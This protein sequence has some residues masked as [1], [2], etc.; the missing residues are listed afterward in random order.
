MEGHQEAALGSTVSFWML[1]IGFEKWQLRITESSP[2]LFP[3]HVSKLLFIFVGLTVLR[4]QSCTSL[5]YKVEA[6]CLNAEPRTERN[7][8]HPHSPAICKTIGEGDSEVSSKKG[9]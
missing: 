1:G 6:L 8:R 9:G 5:S 4:W 2:N 7:N 3:S